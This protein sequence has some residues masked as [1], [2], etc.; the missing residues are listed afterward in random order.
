MGI[1]EHALRSTRLQDVGIPSSGARTSQAS[2]H[3]SGTCNPK[4]QLEMR[5]EK[6]A[7]GHYKVRTEEHT[8]SRQ[9]HPMFRSTHPFPAIAHLP[10]ARYLEIKLG[11]CMLSRNTL[12]SAQRVDAEHKPRSTHSVHRARHIEHAPKMQCVHAQ[13]A[14]R[15]QCTTQGASHAPVM[16]CA[17]HSGA[18]CAPT[19]VGHCTRSQWGAMCVHPQ[20][21]TTRTALVK[22]CA[23]VPVR[24]Q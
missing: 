18:L 2:M 6:H 9:V 24:A 12:R 16:A 19:P 23:C 7:T 22:C 13:N 20:C 15:S 11:A 10:G 5:S 1:T 4:M 14:L 3:Q 8:L 17:N 21:G